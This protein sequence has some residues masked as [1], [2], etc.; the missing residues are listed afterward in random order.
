MPKEFTLHPNCHL[1]FFSDALRMLETYILC[2]RDGTLPL[3]L[4]SKNWLFAHEKG[5]HDYFTSMEEILPEG[6]RY[7]NV[8][9]DD[10]N[11]REFT[12]RQYKDTIA[13]LFQ[14]QPHI[15]ARAETLKERMNL[16]DDYIAV[17]IRRGDK[18]VGESV[19]IPIEFYV[20]RA[21]ES[22]PSHIFIQT[23]DFRA[24]QEFCSVIGRVAPH[25][26]VATTCPQDKFGMFYDPLDMS[27]CVM[28]SYRIGEE[29]VCNRQGIQYL[30]TNAPQKSI[31]EL[32][33]SQMKEHVE[34]MLTGVILCQK[35][36]YVILDHQSNVGRFIS[37][38]HT[39]GREAV[40]AIEDLRIMVGPQNYL[41]PFYDY[42]D[43]MIISNPRYHS[44]HNGYRGG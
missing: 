9:Y 15:H 11:R 24:V 40:L 10:C 39:H 31:L 44:I 17:F 37:F 35:A 21:L 33:K 14:I 12:V 25:V 8:N 42:T 26:K 20:Q 2:K 16:P 5:W 30:E 4:D 29:V 1:G 27:K 36:R 34:E 32:T 38:T 6:P 13:E 43:D 22:K 23:D 3:Y 7:E 18:L 41:L 19:F 28:T